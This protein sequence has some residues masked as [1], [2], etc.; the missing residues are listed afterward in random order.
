MG[1]V[2]DYQYRRM[3][4]WKIFADASPSRRGSLP[5]LPDPFA[6]DFDVDTSGIAFVICAVLGPPWPFY[7]GACPPFC[8]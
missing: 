6:Y 7:A 1:H 5:G 8:E 2:R 3:K 4:P